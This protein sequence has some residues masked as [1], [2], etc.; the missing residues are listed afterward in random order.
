MG[1]AIAAS[2]SARPEV[3]GE[4]V[5]VVRG[6]DTPKMKLGSM[7]DALAHFDAEVQMGA[8]PRHAAKEASLRTGLVARDIYARAAGRK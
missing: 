1:S 2:L 4:I 8:T 5:L 3:L 7:E 6:A